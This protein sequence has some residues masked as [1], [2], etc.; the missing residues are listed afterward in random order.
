MYTKVDECKGAGPPWV[1]QSRREEGAAEARPPEV[2]LFA[3]WL[4]WVEGGAE[5]GGKEVIIDASSASSQIRYK[6]KARLRQAPRRAKI[7][8]ALAVAAQWRFRRFGSRGMPL[9]ISCS[10]A[11]SCGVKPPRY[12]TLKLPSSR[13]STGSEHKNLP[14]YLGRYTKPP[15]RTGSRHTCS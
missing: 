9:T 10:S 14:R 13:A 4:S 12:A 7:P 3:A 2:E 1:N 8:A 6:N 11:W 5:G 15:T